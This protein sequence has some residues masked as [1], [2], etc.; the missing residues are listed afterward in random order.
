MPPDYSEA[1]G[2]QIRMRQR[3]SKR[4]CVRRRSRSEGRL[5]E[6]AAKELRRALALADELG[7]PLTRWRSRVTLAEAADPH[8][9]ELLHDAKSIIREIVAG[10]NPGRA[11]TYLAAPE[12]VRVLERAQ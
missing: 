3:V 11:A 4:F 8:A 10:L 2:N 6:G 9:E 5:R 7:S 12:V 1:R